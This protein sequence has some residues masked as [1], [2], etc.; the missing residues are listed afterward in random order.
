MAVRICEDQ[1][2]HVPYVLDLCQ[3]ETCR[4]A[5]PAFLLATV[6]M[7]RLVLG[8]LSLLHEGFFSVVVF[9]RYRH[10]PTRSSDVWRFG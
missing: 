1:D 2:R 3:V 9:G 4:Y 6:D 8:G 10:F 7:D 5:A